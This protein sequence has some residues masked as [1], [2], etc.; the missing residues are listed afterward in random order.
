MEILEGEGGRGKGGGGGGGR[1]GGGRG[2]GG[3]GGGR[4]EKGEFPLSSFSLQ[5]SLVTS[6]F[7]PDTLVT[8]AS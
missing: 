3:G 5:V 2:R 4:G 6:P 1:G 7:S 8:Q